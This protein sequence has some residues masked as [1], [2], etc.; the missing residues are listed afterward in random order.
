MCKMGSGTD[1]PIYFGD[2]KI[3]KNEYPK[4]TV[5]NGACTG[6][7]FI[8]LLSETHPTLLK[9]SRQLGMKEINVRQGYA[10]CNIVVLDDDSMITGDYGIYQTIT[11][12]SSADCLLVSSGNVLLEGFQVGFIGG[13]S[14]KVGNSII[15]HGNL[16]SHPDSD[17]IIAFIQSKGLTPVWFESFPLTDIGS[18]IEEGIVK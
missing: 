7:Y 18:I 5:Y 8:H 6:K 17:K 4:D 13:A 16:M 3:L 15:F 14:G 9:L 11:R 10:K 2:K 12:N 1:S